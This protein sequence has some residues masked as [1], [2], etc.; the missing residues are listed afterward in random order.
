MT[1]EELY[2]YDLRGYQY[3]ENAI[4]PNLLK[5][6]NERM[7]LWQE[8]A[9]GLLDTYE[10]ATS[11]PQLDWR[12]NIGWDSVNNAV[13]PQV[14][15]WDII[16]MDEAF[17][18]LVANPRVL[19][20]IDQMVSYPRLKSNW[21]ALKWKGG[22]ARDTS[23]H[24]PSSTCN[25]YHF[26]GGRIYHNL[27]Q[28]FYAISDV[29]PGGGG[30]RLIPG[31]HKSNIPLP[32]DDSLEDLEVEI[33][34]KAGSV[35][36]FTHDE[37]HASLN[38]TDT[39]RRVAIFTYC[40]GVIANSWSEPGDTMYD[41]LFEEAPE[42]SWRKYLLRRPNGYKETYPKPEGRAYDAG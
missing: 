14:E 5:R 3:I 10:K 17:V 12:T 18:D 29:P 39:V 22:R 23:N 8:K 34:M 26:N 4:E 6:L 15:F 11:K 38:T 24:T 2:R 31:S 13:R 20:Y 32:K 30:M 36:L 42:G 33:P 40:P 41:R 1:A 27:F 25:F 21:L 16:N 7:D 28:V 9:R 35:L 37:Y 19:P